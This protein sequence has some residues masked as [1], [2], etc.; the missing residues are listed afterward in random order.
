MAILRPNELKDMAAGQ[1]E[2]KI[3]E[4]ETEYGKMKSQV[5]S[6]GAPE[7]SG[8]MREIRRTIA[9]LKHIYKEKGSKLDTK[10]KDNVRNLQ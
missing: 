8:R 1:I 2:A 3:T 4:L 5:R 7:N 6:G 10:I 9:R